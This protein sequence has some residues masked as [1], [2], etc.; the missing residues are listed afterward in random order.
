MEEAYFNDIKLYE[1]IN[2]KAL[3]KGNTPTLSRCVQHFNDLNAMVKCLALMAKHLGRP[4]GSKIQSNSDEEVEEHE[5]PG[6]L[7]TCP[8][9]GRRREA[10][11]PQQYLI[12]ERRQRNSSKAMYS[13]RRSSLKHYLCMPTITHSLS[14]RVRRSNFLLENTLIHLCDLAEVKIYYLQ[15]YTLFLASFSL[16]SR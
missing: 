16:H 9:C 5:N 3:E 6:I 12:D 7:A 4:R 8:L 11:I 15:K 1:M 10:M 2:I 13:R 14:M